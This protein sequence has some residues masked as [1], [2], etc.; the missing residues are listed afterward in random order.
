MVFVTQKSYL[1]H[2][3][4]SFQLQ[5]TLKKIANLQ[6][7]WTAGKSLALPDTLSKITP[8]EQLTRITTIEIPRFIKKNFAENKISPRLE[9]IYAKK[10]DIDKN[11]KINYRIF[12]FIWIAKKIIEFY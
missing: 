11:K 1:N 4:Y 2:R 9:C 7:V 3:L 8:T 10:I 5:L 12:H 6:R